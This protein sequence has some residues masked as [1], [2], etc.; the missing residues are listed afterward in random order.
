MIR[1][2]LPVLISELVGAIED[3][4]LRVDKDTLETMFASFASV[5]K[6]RE[7]VKAAVGVDPLARKYR[8]GSMNKARLRR[9]AA[10]GDENAA[11]IMNFKKRKVIYDDLQILKRATEG[12]AFKFEFTLAKTGR[13]YTTNRAITLSKEAR[14]CIIPW[15]GKKFYAYDMDQQEL[16]LIAAY[17]GNETLKRALADG[18]DIHVRTAETAKVQHDRGTGKEMNYALMYG[19]EEGDYRA[20]YGLKEEQLKG[21]YKYLPVDKLRKITDKMLDRYGCIITLYGTRIACEDPASGPAYLI[22]GTGSDLSRR[23]L[24]KISKEGL[25]L[26]MFVHDCFYFEDRIAEMEQLDVEVR[27][28]EFPMKLKVGSNWAE[29]TD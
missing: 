12:E 14:T 29:V 1:E 20:K 17:T 6:E 16:R 13:F 24:M 23:I 9:L 28:V 11:E 5:P 21:I 18:E 22:Q 10:A 15:K 19:M 7:I 27:G 2:T 3:R 8:E 25:F 26:T 4:G